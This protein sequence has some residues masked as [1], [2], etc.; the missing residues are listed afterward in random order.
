ME[1][2]LFQKIME[3]AGELN[4]PNRKE[5]DT[6]MKTIIIYTSQTGFTKKYAEWIAQDT[7]GELMTLKEAEKKPDTFFASFDTIIYGGWI[8]AGTIKKSKWFTDRIGKWK[9][10]R[11]VLF[12]V[13]AS[14]ASDKKEIEEMFQNVLTA[15]QLEY[16]QTYYCQGGVNYDRMSLSSKLLLKAL[17]SSLK[18][19]E[20]RTEKEESMLEILSENK[21]CSDKA[22]IDPIVS[23]LKG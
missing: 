4:K 19:K 7:A 1:L 8:M 5:L 9:S 18:K 3:K 20:S 16:V 14:P 13:G 23:Y 10:K 11:L 22:F 6:T 12:G 21:D 17:A 15:E 2:L